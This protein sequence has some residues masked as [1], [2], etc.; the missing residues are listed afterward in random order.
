MKKLL[1]ALLFVGFTAPVALA[2]DTTAK[3]AANMPA[4][5]GCP[6]MQQ[7]MPCCCCR[8][9]QPNPATPQQAPAPNK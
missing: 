9:M 1:I 2:A 3:P 8:G 5:Q 7:M 4:M 6:M